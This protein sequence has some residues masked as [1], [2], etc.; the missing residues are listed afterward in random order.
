MLPPLSSTECP[1]SRLTATGR[2]SPKAT[3]VAGMRNDIALRAQGMDVAPWCLGTSAPTPEDAACAGA[4]V[5]LQ[6]QKSPPKLLF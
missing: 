4:P 3:V 1:C 2:R 5:L 6:G